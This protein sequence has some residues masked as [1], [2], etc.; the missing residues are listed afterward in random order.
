MPSTIAAVVARLGRSRALT[1][2]VGLRSVARG[3]GVVVGDGSGVG[4]ACRV[5]RDGCRRVVRRNSRWLHDSML[6]SAGMI[7]ML[8]AIERIKSSRSSVPI[9]VEA[10]QD[11]DILDFRSDPHGVTAG[12][13]SCHQAV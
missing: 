9:N 1:G 2:W 10:G 11:P 13:H 3:A 7:H 5:F 12:V 6:L 8:E 4:W